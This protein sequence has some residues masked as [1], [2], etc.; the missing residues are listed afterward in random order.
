M[1]PS[2]LQSSFLG[3]GEKRRLSQSQAL[4]KISLSHLEPFSPIR[5]NPKCEATVGADID[6]LIC[7]F[8]LLFFFFI[9]GGTVVVFDNRDGD[10]SLISAGLVS[11]ALIPCERSPSR[12]V[13]ISKVSI[14]VAPS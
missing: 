11:P 10:V 6:I 3:A 13:S 1:H 8:C 2:V 5:A 9:V 4:R 12:P 14:G 7:S